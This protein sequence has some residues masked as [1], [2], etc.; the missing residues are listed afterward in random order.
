MFVRADKTH[1]VQESAQH[2]EGGLGLRKIEGGF[3][4]RQTWNQQGGSW[5]AWEV[6]SKRPTAELRV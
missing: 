3:P 4:E 2:S 5:W 6:V 1:Q